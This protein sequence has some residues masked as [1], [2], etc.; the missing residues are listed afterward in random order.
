MWFGTSDGLNRYDGYR[1]KIYRHDYRNKNSINDNRITVLLEDKEGKIWAG[2]RNNG[3][4]VFDSHTER[5]THFTPEAGNPKSI[6]G[7][8]VTSL[9]RDRE[10]NIWVGLED[11]GVCRFNK[12][13]RS[14]TRFLHNSKDPA[15]LRSNFVGKVYCDREGIVWVGTSGGILHRW[16]PG[17]DGFTSYSFP[18]NGKSSLITAIYRD[19][20]DESWIGTLNNGLFRFDEK[21]RNFLRFST[22]KSQ[23]GLTPDFIQDVIQ[24]RSGLI[25]IATNGGGLYIFNKQSGAISS[26]L[27][28]P[29]D[30]NSL[31]SSILQQIYEDSE[32]IVWIASA[33]GGVNTWDPKK[34]KFHHYKFEIGNPHSISNNNVFCFYEDKDGYIWI[35]TDGGG[36]NRFDRKKSTFVHYLHDPS[37]PY[38]ICENSALSIR[39]DQ[40]GFLWVVTYSK[41]VS[42]FDRKTGRFYYYRGKENI[43]ADELSIFFLSLF[44]DSSGQIWVISLGGGI[45]RLDTQTGEVTYYRHDLSNR[46]SLNHNFVM[47]MQEDKPGVLWVGTVGGGLDLF[48]TKLN[49]FTHYMHDQNDPRSISSNALRSLL[50]DKK[51]TLWIGTDNAGLNRFDRQTGTFSHFDEN[52]GLPNNSIHALVEDDRGYIWISTNSG[53]S[54]F[55]PL[56]GTFRNYGVHDGLQNN[57]FIVGAA[58]KS[59]DGDLFFGGINGFNAFHPS[60]IHDYPNHAPIVFTDFQL[61]NRSVPIGQTPDNRKI[62][63][64]SV[65]YTKKIEL[66]YRDSIFALEFAALNYTNPNKGR[67]LYKLEGADEDWISTKNA[68]FAMYS[69]IPPG[70]YV[71]RVKNANSDGTWNPSEARLSIIIKPP[72]YREWWFRLLLLCVFLALVFTAHKIRYQR[73]EKRRLELEETVKERTLELSLKKDRLEKI[74]RIMRA[75]NREVTLVRVLRAILKEI[76]VIRGIEKACALIYDKYQGFFQYK[77]TLGWNQKQLK[78]FLLSREEVEERFIHNSTEIYKD[79]FLRVKIDWPQKEDKVCFMGTPKTLLVMRIQQDG[80]VEGY[81]IFANMQHDDAFKDQDLRLLN[82]LKTHI[83]SAF[84]KSR[85]LQELK[86]EREIAQDANESKSMFLARM[87]HEIR[88]PL[89]GI[90]GFAEMLTDTNL[91][92]DQKDYTRTISQSGESLLTLLNDILDFSKIEAGQLVFESLD[93]DPEITIFDICQII[94]P[95]ISSKP[96]EILAHIGDGVP[97]YVKGDPGRFRQ[98][99]LNLMGNAA[100]FTEAGEI[101]LSIDVEEEVDQRLKLHARIRDTGIGIP[102]DKL[103]KIFDVFQQADGSTTRKYGG[104]GLGLAI[105]RHI[106]RLMNGNVWAEST[107]AKGS[108]FHFVAWMEKSEK[109]FFHHRISDFLTGKRILAIDDNPRNLDIITYILTR[110]GVRVDVLASGN[111]VIPSLRQALDS[112]DPYHLCIVDIMMPDLNGFELAQMIR[113]HPASFSS[114][115]LLAFSSSAMRHSQK[116]QEYGFNGYLSK[117]IRKKL[118]LQMLER[119][120]G[121]VST[122]TPQDDLSRVVVTRHILV[123][124]AKHS[125]RILLVEDNPINQ[126]LSQFILNRSGYRIEIANNGKEAVDKV[127]ADPNR[128]DIIFMD[129]Q[130]PEMDGLEATR[131]IRKLGFIHLPVI[132]MTAEAMKGDREKCLDAGMNDY[133]SKPIKREKVFEIIKKWALNQ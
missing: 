119:L 8:S 72:F 35:G 3:L 92:A 125:I 14:F 19:N 69:S 25:W 110:S 66:S 111:P 24:D 78:P 89:N 122:E 18:T 16:N 114:I 76:M 20:D 26:M 7:I 5:F 86:K 93:F 56:T 22:G 15:S 130:M 123:E 98:V 37:N 6:A 43:N 129:I 117:P 44:K 60:E 80:N 23:G 67:Y 50:K 64:Q 29:V 53:I 124:E 11:S 99:L 77:A 84:V 34:Y 108:I 31:G 101:E 83:V 96:I 115:P 94:L 120:L 33:Y 109:H 97:A 9:C 40:N 106:A 65:T 107:P 82:D 49:R 62:L 79:I 36:I 13:D 81:L 59:A 1:F 133:I 126:K 58:A 46:D 112:G 63:E 38:S 121:G 57:I 103:E 85:L 39:E 70:D 75:V 32:G 41:G 12:Q 4:D 48:D 52:R 47:A 100:K 131:Q 128:Y 45:G 105:S 104:S 88:T 10:G 74:E 54:R 71:F 90:I 28:S 55:D 17:T 91:N 127:T 132:A 21:K 102:P 73:L 2:T 30:R 68:P 118:L 113:K 116:F 61:F 87:S 27:P 95:R 51:G 42:R